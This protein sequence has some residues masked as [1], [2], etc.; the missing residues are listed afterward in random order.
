[1]NNMVAKF[2]VIYY[3]VF[4]QIN[5]FQVLCDRLCCVLTDNMVAKFYVI[6]Y[7]GRFIVWKVLCD[8]LLYFTDLI[9]AIFYLIDYTYYLFFTDYMFA[10][11]YVRGYVVFGQIIY[12]ESTQSKRFHHSVRNSCYFNFDFDCY[13]KHNNVISTNHAKSL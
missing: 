12:L 13:R 10:K 2:Y 9:Y 7:V 6:D 4:G 5:V 11:F 8:R 1:M 3:I